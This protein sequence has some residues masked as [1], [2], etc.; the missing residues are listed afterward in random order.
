M[1]QE[2]LM[3]V[4]AKSTGPTSSPPSASGPAITVEPNVRPNLS[5]LPRYICAGDADIRLSGWGQSR[6]G[7]VANLSLSGCCVKSEFEFTVGDQVEMILEVDGM[8][9]RVAGRVIHV[10]PLDMAEGKVRAPGMGIEFQKM[11][12]GARVCLETLITELN[13]TRTS[14]ARR[15]AHTRIRSFLPQVGE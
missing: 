6:T 14:M 13:A 11:S 10:P 4:D 7:T 3:K 15:P 1:P 5:I 9:F 8:S 12:A 2:Y